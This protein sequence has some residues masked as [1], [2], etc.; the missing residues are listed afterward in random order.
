MKKL[1]LYLLVLI[2]GVLLLGLC[3]L[4]FI[5]FLFNSYH[6]DVIPAEKAN[7]KV[8]YSAVHQYR[9][10]HGGLPSEEGFR[11]ELLECF[12]DV[13]ILPEFKYFRQEDEFVLVSPG[14]NKKYDTPDGFENIKNFKGESD[15]FILFSPFP[16]WRKD[17]Q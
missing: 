16:R 15:D 5:L 9:I 1:K 17:D 6:I 13:N 2:V 11:D 4:A 8:L 10:E 3:C 7:L 14:K 12:E